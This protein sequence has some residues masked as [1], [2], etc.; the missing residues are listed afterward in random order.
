MLQPLASSA[1]VMSEQD[2][3]AGIAILDIGGGTTDLAVFYEGILKHTAVIPFGGENITNDIKMG[4][5]VLKSHAEQMKLQFGS[6]LA[7]A[8]HNN[9]FIKIPS[10]RGLPSKDISVKNLAG[11]IQARM[12]E[13]L[14]FVTFHLKQVGLDNKML[15]GGIVLTG[16]GSQL[17]HLIQLTEYV[18]GLNA[19]IGYPN[20]HLAGNHI[21]GMEKPMYAT[22][23]GL[24]LKGYNVYESSLNELKSEN[25]NTEVEVIN[26]QPEKEVVIR[27]INKKPKSFKEFMTSIKGGV[28]DLFKEE[29]DLKL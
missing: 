9:A 12:S 21:E 10:L 8:A 4:L 22:C 15:N 13:I 29:G 17:K 24:I 7:D 25:T 18:T 5:G 2:I 14:A 23:I 20:E 26:N 16:G 3:E 28:I 19:R 1:A 27:V 11:I 6:A